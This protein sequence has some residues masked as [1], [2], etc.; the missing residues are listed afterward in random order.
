M[1]ENTFDREHI[2]HPYS[3]FN[4][5]DPVYKV[6]SC[7]KVRLKLENGKELIDGMS[8]WWAAVHGYNVSE[9][10]T[11]VKNQL[12][13]MS[14][15]MFGGIT[16]DPATILSKKLI[17]ITPKGLDKV[18]LSDSGS[19]SVEVAMKMALQYWYSKEVQGKNKF[20]TIKSGYHGDT[21]NAM[22]VCDPVTGM[23]EIFS[24]ILPQNYFADSPKCGFYDEWD[25][26]DIC[27]FRKIIEKENT[28]IAAVILEPIVQGAGGMR[29]YHPQYLKEVRNLCDKYDILLIFDEIATGFGRTGEFWGCDHSKITPDIMCIGK[30]LTGGYMTLAATLTNSKVADGISN[31][32]TPVFM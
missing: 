1:N 6:I 9:L 11:V 17:E 21:F 2:W 16:H 3:S 18:F 15:V 20:L 14:H 30:A 24:G 7:D 28:N 10:N 23:H 22:S 26:K 5:S 25:D 8:S 13:K 31:G 32:K 27:S 12:K 19:V 29:F 4:S